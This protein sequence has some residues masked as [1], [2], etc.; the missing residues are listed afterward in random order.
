M[1]YRLI[2][3]IGRGL[4]RALGMK[5]TL[6]GLQHLPASGGAVLAITHFS[7]LDFV[8][9]GWVSHRKNGRLIRFLATEQAFHH[10]VAGPLMRAMKHVP[11]QRSGGGAA[12]QLAVRRLGEGELIGVFPESRVTR[13]FTLLPFK[14]GAARMAADAGVPLVPMVIW[15]THRILTRTHRSALRHKLGVP[16]TIVVGEALHP[17]PQ[18]DPVNVTEQL[19]ARMTALLEQAQRDYPLTADAGA[20]WQPA[21]LAG[22]APTP[23]QAAELDADD[24]VAIADKT[25]KKPSSTHHRK[26]IG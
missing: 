19:R 16:V 3:L 12:Y 8:L 20:W 14:T 13:T 21:H 10:P 26:A 2:V 9:A 15:G 1:V 5:R 18:A 6:T 7:Y 17:G 23:E 22:G 11:V 4:L 24:P 25:A